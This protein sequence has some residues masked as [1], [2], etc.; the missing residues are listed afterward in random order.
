MMKTLFAAATVAAAMLAGAAQAAEDVKVE[1]GVLKCTMT[2]RTN[3][4]LVSSTTFS[5]VF[6]RSGENENYVGEITA[7]GLDLTLKA[8]EK[9]IWAVFAPNSA[10]DRSG[11]LEGEYGGVSA[12]VA[13]GVGAAGKV[14]VGGFDKSVALQPLSVSGQKGVGA[15]LGIEGLKL[16]LE[17]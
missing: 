5:C 16:S 1:T 2:D 15:S 13:L 14:L 8:E 17:K 9:L 11:I 4:V 7:V 12:S 6:D 3:L 10:K